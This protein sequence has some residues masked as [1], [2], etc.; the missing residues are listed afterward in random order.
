[1]SVCV[2]QLQKAC[3]D[4]EEVISPPLPS[5]MLSNVLG[6]L[7]SAVLYTEILFWKAQVIRLHPEAWDLITL[8]IVAWKVTHVIRSP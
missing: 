2:Y 8:I 3:N 4:L 5:D 6:Q 1:M 7:C